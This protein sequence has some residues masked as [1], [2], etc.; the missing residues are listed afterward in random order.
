[1]RRVEQKDVTKDMERQAERILAMGL[2]RGSEREF[3]SDGTRFIGRV[4]EH[5]FFGADPNKPHVKHNGVSLFYADEP[6]VPPQVAP[7]PAK[8]SEDATLVVP[9]RQARNYTKWSLPGPR[10]I[11]AIVIHTAEC[12]ETMLA[13]ENLSDWGAGPQAPKASWHYAVDADSYSQSVREQDIAWHAPGL[14][15]ASIGIELA[16]RAGQKLA[17]WNDAYSQSML[18]LAARLVARLCDKYAILPQ[19]LMAKDLVFSQT[20]GITGHADVSAAFKRSTHWDPGPFFPWEQFLAHVR[21]MVRE[22]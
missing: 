6:L 22:P 8:R 13:A 1:M 16:G 9:F 15:T 11:R 12:S 2:Q 3:V 5:T 4:E 21:G 18:G 17:E 20:T 7:T 14:N 19:R 10:K